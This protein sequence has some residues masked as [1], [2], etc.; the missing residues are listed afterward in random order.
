[1]ES[2]YKEQLQNIVTEFSLPLCSSFYRTTFHYLI[3]QLKTIE[4]N[5]FEY[6][7]SNSQLHELST[8]LRLRSA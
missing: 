2:I 5:N 4:C 8:S 3:V 1:M 7:L 6:Y